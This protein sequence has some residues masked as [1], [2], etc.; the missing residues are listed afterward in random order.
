MTSIGIAG[1]LSA[2]GSR[3]ELVAG[4]MRPPRPMPAGIPRLWELWEARK[5]IA[6]PQSVCISFT[7]AWRNAP[8]HHGSARNSRAAATILTSVG[9]TSSHFRVFSPQSGL[10]QSCRSDTR[11]RANTI[12]CLI[13]AAAGM[14]GE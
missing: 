7:K 13:S 11:C 8:H 12:S 6:G 4:C 9:R 14:R 3:I 5:D 2:V 10:I 1:R